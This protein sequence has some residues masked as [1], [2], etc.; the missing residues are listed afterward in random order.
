[1]KGLENLIENLKARVLN[2]LYTFKS[3]SI[4]K[5]FVPVLE[6][7]SKSLLV[8][9]ECVCEVDFGNKSFGLP[10]KKKKCLDLLILLE[11]Q[12]AENFD[13]PKDHWVVN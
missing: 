7:K 1:M 11:R 5:F 12:S 4:D 2:E 10:Q 6:G 8:V 13:S 3:K 9:V